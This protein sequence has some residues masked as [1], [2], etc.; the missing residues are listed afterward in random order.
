MFEPS[1]MPRSRRERR[2]RR[3]RFIVERAIALFVD[4]G[5]LGVRMADVAAACDLSMGTIYSH[6]AAKED[7]LL[8][9]A[10]FLAKEEKKIFGRII[11]SDA[12]A[13]E[14]IV[15]G[16]TANWLISEH[17]PALVEIDHL[18]LMPSVWRRA[19]PQRIREL[20]ELHKAFFQLAQMAVL[21]MLDAELNGHAALDE[22]K[23]EELASIV[24]FGMWGL[25]V[26]LNSTAQSGLM[27]SGSEERET[28]TREVCSY[29]LFTANVIYFLKGCGWRESEPEQVF[30]TCRKNAEAALC[31]NPWFACPQSDNG[32]GV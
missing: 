2:D 19:Q 10:A 11:A 8:A 20:G 24:N 18:S 21:E 25:C 14:R 17:H 15:T 32:E 26:G 9:C 1:A 4:R 22:T 30:N 3:E 29:M 23:K 31:N 5:F 12:P 6:F 28:C 13:V 27:R 16:F 7:L